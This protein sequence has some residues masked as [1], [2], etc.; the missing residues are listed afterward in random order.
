MSQNTSRSDAAH[1]AWETRR[2]RIARPLI[3]A[4]T[5]EGRIL[6]HAQRAASA[7]IGRSCKTGLPCDADW[8]MEATNRIIEQGFCCAIT[9]VKFDV[10]FRT[11]W[12]GMECVAQ[13]R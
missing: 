9:G 13:A 8:M 5:P 1:K 7:A 6:R 2:K 10:D 12:A 3:D 11:K 4:N